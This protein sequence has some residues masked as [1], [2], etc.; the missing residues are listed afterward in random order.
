MISYIVPI[1][2]SEKTIASCLESILAQNVEKEILAI[3]NNS[4]DKSAEIIK[5][6]PV[7]YFCEMK[8]G[9]AAAKNKGLKELNHASTYVAFVDSDVVLPN[10]WT[11]KALKLLEK[12][13][14]VCGVGGHGK[15][16]IMNSASEIFDNLLYGK[17]ANQRDAIVKSLATMDVMYRKES[18]SNMFF[19]E[20]LIAAEDPDFNFRLNQ[21]NY[22]L[23]YSSELWVYH[24]NP[25]R[26]MI[27]MKKWFNYGKFYPLPYFLNNELMDLGLWI[28]LL[29]APIIIISLFYGIMTGNA[30]PISISFLLMPLSYFI[31]AIK[32]RILNPNKLYIFIIFHTLKQWS[33]I[34]GIWYGFLTKLKRT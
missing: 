18:I 2:N 16:I 23:L 5:K 26:I 11:I 32:S 17:N 13:A 25:T 7:K 34:A 6:Y 24:H 28:R 14:G 10:D 33:Q 31:I 12:H 1:Y 9:P 27:A 20:K 8:R 4:S 19:N 21:K 29:Y 3:D 22:K 15:S 30:L